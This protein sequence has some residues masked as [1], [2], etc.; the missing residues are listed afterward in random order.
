M[1]MKTPS[2]QRMYAQGEAAVLFALYDLLYDFFGL[3]EL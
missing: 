3:Y 2:P 1:N